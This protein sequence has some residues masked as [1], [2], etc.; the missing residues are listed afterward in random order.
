M[1]SIASQGCC[2]VV[3]RNTD[4]KLLCLPLS[5]MT[6]DALIVDVSARVTLT[7]IFY[8]PSDDSTTRA[9][10]VLPL[11]ARAAVCAF[12]MCC[13]DRVIRGIVKEQAQAK[14]EHIQAMREEK[15]TSLVEWATDDI[16]TIS[17]GAI[18]GQKVVT[19]VLT[20][21]M[22]LM[23]GDHVDEI[24]FQ[25]PTS[26]GQRYGRVP[27]GMNDAST[28]AK[29]TRIKMKI[30]VQ[31]QGVI[32][33]IAS[34]THPSFRVLPYGTH[35]DRPS[36]HR[37][38]AIFSSTEYLTSDVVLCITAEGLDR[39][40]CFI[41]HH[42]NIS[43]SVA[44]QLTL[45]PKFELPP[46]PM[47]EYIFVLDRS[48]SMTVGSPQ[49]IDMARRTLIMLLHSLP[50]NGTS[51]N[52]LTF[53]N[54]PFAFY[55]T[56]QPYNQATLCDAVARVEK[57]VPDGG[58][59]LG[60]ALNFALRR[61][62]TS[63]PTAMFVLTDG[64]VYDVDA[65]VDVVARAVAQ[66]PKNA[67]IQVFALGIGDT[68]STAVCEGMARAGNGVSLMATDAESIL[69]KCTKLVRAGRSFVFKNVAV[70]WG[71]SG[72]IVEEER[73]G[74]AVRF[75]ERDVKVQQTPAS[76][77]SLYHGHRSVV[78]ALIKGD[79]SF[80]LP[81][82]VT[83]RAYREGHTVPI[84]LKIP[85]E[86]VKFTDEKP[87]IP[88]IHT[89]AA[90][91]L[92]TDIQDSIDKGLSPD[93][94]KVSI[95]RLGEQYQLASRYTSFIAVEDQWAEPAGTRRHSI[96]RFLKHSRTRGRDLIPV[97]QNVEAAAFSI[98]SF[99]MSALDYTSVFFAAAADVFSEPYRNISSSSA[100]SQIR[101]IPGQYR[102]PT[103]DSTTS[104]QAADDDIPADE[105]GYDT[106]NTFT[107]LSSLE[108]SSETDW[109][110]SEPDT[111]SGPAPPTDDPVRSR[112]P[113][114]HSSGSSGDQPSPRPRGRKTQPRP[115]LPPPPQVS[116]AV[117]SLVRLQSFDGSFT[118]NEQLGRIVGQ[119]AVDDSARPSG[120]TA[121]VWATALAV[122]YFRKHLT[123]QPD[124]LE[125]MMEKAME[126]VDESNSTGLAA[127]FRALID[128]A[129][130]LVN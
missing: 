85:V 104:S 76:I 33:S 7:Q 68:V 36:R 56:S 70:D 118:L 123:G 4:G 20:F 112:S 66:A 114:L 69:P 62:S 43:Q 84:E 65:T 126:Y 23:T 21:M 74:T 15:L 24:R 9:K 61:R 38:T 31:T 58:T 40:R 50:R 5:Q 60:L 106:D 92:I 107:T 122:A 113:E 47:K 13:G 98:A 130:N 52:I 116:D 30:N 42:P 16:F 3:H 109:S 44:M 64:E 46:N 90:R 72:D 41:E 2:G 55:G 45:V 117:Y 22:D 86:S 79:E 108:G 127:S 121:Q 97:P 71:L 6:V 94:K 93:D 11:P 124:L 115:A 12:E 73:Q 67:P 78:F 19:T 1:A 99:V 17:I 91:R 81:D 96:T 125:S 8:N 32:K 57:I 110:D 39:P 95:I 28:P 37:M 75:A 18:P 34:P 51:F 128:L 87:S 48:S 102:P 63:I 100:S 120:V 14:E 10:Y 53:S 26:I 80:I 119:A 82:S 35:R 49:R 29:H 27:D 103:P 25:L 129:A 54:T 83:L 77:E 105:D 59:E 89:L 111:S 88:L 101:N